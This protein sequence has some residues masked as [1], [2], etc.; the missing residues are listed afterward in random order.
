MGIEALCG[1][2]LGGSVAKGR[3]GTTLDKT[4][5]CMVTL[6]YVGDVIIHPQAS[7]TL[8]LDD[9]RKKNPYSWPYSQPLRYQHW[10]MLP[11]ANSPLHA[12]PTQL[13]GGLWAGGG[14]EKGQ[15]AP[16]L[17]LEV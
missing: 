12:V 10:R 6:P 7:P 5:G 4:Q 14:V 15:F 1:R 2:L 9:L 11:I 8:A 17:G 3:W 13:A 16:H